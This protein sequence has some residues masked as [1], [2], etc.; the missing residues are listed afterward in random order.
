MRCALDTAYAN[1]DNVLETPNAFDAVVP[2]CRPHS[3]YH[4]IPLAVFSSMF[5]NGDRLGPI[6]R[7][8]KI[9]AAQQGVSKTRNQTDAG[10]SW[11]DMTVV[12]VKA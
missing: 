3:A 4:M 9:Y 7:N 8:T 5:W 6:L 11:I 1:A 10:H 12:E 2:R